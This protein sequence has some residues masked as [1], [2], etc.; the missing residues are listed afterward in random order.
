MSMFES[1]LCYYIL[2]LVI[3]LFFND[4]LVV[5]FDNVLNYYELNLNDILDICY[6]SFIRVNNQYFDFELLIY[7]L[8]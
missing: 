2:V 5:E 3:Q 6:D 4:L 1:Y 8:I 7:K